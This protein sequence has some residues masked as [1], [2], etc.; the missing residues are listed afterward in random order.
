MGVSA[1]L[2]GI[3]V[4]TS[5]CVVGQV[6]EDE[7]VGSARRAQIDAGQKNYVIYDLIQSGVQIGKVL[8]TNSTAGDGYEANREYWY[9]NANP[10]M[11]SSLKFVGGTSEY[12]S[13]PPSGLG[14]L[15]FVTN[16]TPTW[17]SG[18]P[19]GTLLLESI[20]GTSEKIGINWGMSESGGVWSGSITW[21]H[22]TTGNIF[23]PSTT[24]TL[25]PGT[26]S[27]GTW[28]YYVTS[29]L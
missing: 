12:W 1:A 22:S 26:P 24:N 19:R 27:T 14:T 29:P 4:I 13:T 21:W 2:L 6:E 23:G 16:R 28:Y 9:L 10:S 7:D 15:S 5:G 17:T 18:T 20:A 8:V 25:L 11:S 3:A